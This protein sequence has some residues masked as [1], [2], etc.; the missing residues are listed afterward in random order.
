MNSIC[1]ERIQSSPQLRPTPGRNQTEEH[2]PTSSKLPGVEKVTPLFGMLCH[3]SPPQEPLPDESSLGRS[4]SLHNYYTLV[5]TSVEIRLLLHHI[6]QRKSRFHPP[7]R[8]VT[9]N[10]ATTTHPPHEERQ[11]YNYTTLAPLAEPV[12]TSYTSLI[13]LFKASSRQASQ[14]LHYTPLDYT[15]NIT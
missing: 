3:C 1:K 10:N 11:H 4:Q 12:Q 7:A 8:E 9:P 2:L 14:D 15:R 13:R 6:D 5:S